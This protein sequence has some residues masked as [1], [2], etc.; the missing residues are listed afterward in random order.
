MMRKMLLCGV[1]LLAFAGCSDDKN[2][3]HRPHSQLNYDG[4]VVC[5][6]CESYLS[7]DIFG[8]IGQLVECPECKGKA[9]RGAYCPDLK[10]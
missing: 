8:Q 10:K 9:P 7:N 3:D 2:E 4:R 5:P 6:R 1:L